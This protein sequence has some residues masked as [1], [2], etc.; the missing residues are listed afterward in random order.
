[1]PQRKKQTPGQAKASGR[2]KENKRKR[3]ENSG[4]A[5]YGDKFFLK[6]A[7]QRR[8]TAKQASKIISSNYPV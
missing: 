4:F 5:P 3:L 6:A 8:L 1:M 7:E 2:K